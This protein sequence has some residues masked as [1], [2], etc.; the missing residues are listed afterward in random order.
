[1]IKA[2]GLPADPVKWLI[3]RAKSKGAELSP[4][5]AQMLATKINRGDKNDRDHFDT[6]SRT[7]ILKLDNELEK[8]AAFAL[9]RRIETRDVELLVPDEDVADIFKFIDA[10]SLRNAADA[11]KFVRGV[12]VRGESPLVVL[13]HI[14]RQTRL[15]IQAKDHA[16]MGPEAL[17]QRIGVHPFAAKK[18][19]QQSGR[20]ER[21]ALVET[22]N[23]LLDADI[24]IKTGRMDEGAALDVLIAALCA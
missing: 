9:G 8:L 6:D 4:Q 2:F 11:Y 7:Y 13:S 1:M 20:F 24:A 10:I 21:A 5:A 17:A 23:A 14:A 12:I 18:A 15:L 22:M 3:E 19:M 16:G